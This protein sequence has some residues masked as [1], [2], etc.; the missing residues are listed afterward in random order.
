MMENVDRENRKN[1]RYKKYNAVT[2]IILG[3]F[4]FFLCASGFIAQLTDG[5]QSLLYD[6]LGKTNKWSG[7]FGPQNFVDRM[8]ELSTL[9]SDLFI[10]IFSLIFGGYLFIRKKYRTLYTYFY[11]VLGAAILLIFLKNYYGG[12]AWYNW[13]NIFLN[14]NK[15]FPSGHALMSIVFY[16]TLARLIYRANPDRSINRYLMTLAFILSLAIGL[17]QII[18]SSHSPNEIIAGWALGFAWISAAWLLDHRLRKK[19]HH[20]HIEKKKE[21]TEV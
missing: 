7:T 4:I 14:D 21:L 9:G 12:E 17:S 11:V 13:F 10:S 15:S 1:S 6:W 8:D 5:Y 3:L 19:V 16:F 20:H 2:I 18:K